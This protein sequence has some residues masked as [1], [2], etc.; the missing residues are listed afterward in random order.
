SLFFWS[1]L[2]GWLLNK[3]HKSVTSV[4]KNMTYI[5]NFS[6]VVWTTLVIVMITNFWTSFSTHWIFQRSWPS[7]SKTLEYLREHRKSSDKI[8][9]EAASVYKFHLFDGFEDPSAWPSTWYLEYNGKQGVEA[10]KEAIEDKEFEYI[11][12]SDYFTIE[13]NSE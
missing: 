7:T 12:L 1:P 9:A 13:I 8:L 6:Q 10:M 2:A 3:I 11:I 4:S 5:Q